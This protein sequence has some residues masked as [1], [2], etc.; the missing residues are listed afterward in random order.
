MTWDTNYPP[1]LLRVRPDLEGRA[2]GHQRRHTLPVPPM[3][4]DAAD[5]RIM[6][7]ARPLPLVFS[8]TREVLVVKGGGR[9]RAG[10]VCHYRRALTQLSPVLMLL[11][12]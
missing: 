7:L 10:S 2:G 3:Q 4:F 8:K 1:S 12:S 11:L 9:R 6:L 5:E